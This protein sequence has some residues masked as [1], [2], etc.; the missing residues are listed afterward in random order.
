MQGHHDLTTPNGWFGGD[1][2]GQCLDGVRLLE[3][4]S[5]RIPRIVDLGNIANHL[6]NQGT[7]I[8][9]MGHVGLELEPLATRGIHGDSINHDGGPLD[10]IVSDVLNPL[11]LKAGII[12]R[13][14]GIRILHRRPNVRQVEDKVAVVEKIRDTTDLATERRG[15]TRQRELQSGVIEIQSYRFHRKVR[16][17]LLHRSKERHRGVSVE[18]LILSP[19]CHQLQ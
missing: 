15:G 3:H 5:L 7:L 10:R 8:G 13:R 1:R 19:R 6:I 18:E 12:R 2:G 17:T 14:G 4:T 11:E 9:I 16:L